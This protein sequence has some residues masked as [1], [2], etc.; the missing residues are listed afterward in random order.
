[1]HNKNPLE[2]SHFNRSLNIIACEGLKIQD[3]R[4]N[5]FLFFCFNFSIKILKQNAHVTNPQRNIC[6]KYNKPPKKIH[7]QGNWIPLNKQ[8]NTNKILPILPRDLNCGLETDLQLIW[9]FYL[10]ISYQIKADKCYRNKHIFP[11]FIFN[12]QY[13]DVGFDFFS[14]CSIYK[15]ERFQLSF[16]RINE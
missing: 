2:K 1:M 15:Q 11:R 13:N 10:D 9:N 16:M 6:L 5:T 14:S 8:T 4:T 7:I 12:S 3:S